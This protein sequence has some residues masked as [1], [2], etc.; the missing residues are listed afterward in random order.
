MPI[1]SIETERLV[2][3]STKEEDA[4]FVLQL[5]NTPKWIQNIGDRKI[6]TEEAAQKHILEKMKPQFERLGYGNY[7]IIR[8][9]DGAKLGFAGLY[10]REG[11]EGVD[12]GFGLLPEYEGQ[13]Y[14]YEA[15]K[16]LMEKAFKDFGLKVIKGIVNPDNLASQR[17]LEKLGLR[18]V[19]KIKLGEEGSEVLLYKSSSIIPL[20]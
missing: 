9:K 8:K 15:S 18:Q 2:L 6:Y 14:A 13:G 7:T 12:I 10:D 3:R 11:V 1:N 17:L 19:E 20:S 5:M 4:P 16:V